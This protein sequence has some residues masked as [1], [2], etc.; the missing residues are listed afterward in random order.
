M[1]AFQQV[2]SETL[3]RI[4]SQAP[5]NIARKLPSWLSQGTKRYLKWL[6]GAEIV[7]KFVAI[8]ISIVVL[9]LAATKLPGPTVSY[10]SVVRLIALALAFYCLGSLL[11]RQRS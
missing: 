8:A 7:M 11:F 1:N 10:E 2:L 4:L 5:A 6:W 9:Q 3:A